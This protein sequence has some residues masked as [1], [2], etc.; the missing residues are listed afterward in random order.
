MFSYIIGNLDWPSS[1]ALIALFIGLN[2]PVV[3]WIGSRNT[4]TEK[5]Y[6]L[7]FKKAQAE[8]AS[9]IYR[10]ETNRMMEVRKLDQNLIT[11][12]REG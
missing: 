5:D 1:A 4:K 9:W 8:E 2:V 11:S 3:V 6:E 10:N 12:H 7:D